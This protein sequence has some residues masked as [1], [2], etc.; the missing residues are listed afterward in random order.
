MANWENTS[1]QWGLSGLIWGVNLQPPQTPIA[2]E[3]NFRAPN[4]SESARQLAEHLPQGRAWG[5]KH[6]PDAN[7]H[8]LIRSMAASFNRVQ[9][10]IEKLSRELNLELTD[11][12][13]PEWETSVGL[14]D[15]CQG[16]GQTLQ[17]RR[18]AVISRLRRLPIV[19]KADFEV[20]GEELSGE[21]TVV[22][23]GVEVDSPI[24]EHSRFKLY[25]SFPAQQLGFT[26]DFPVLFGGFRPDIVKCVFEKI[27]PANVVV[28]FL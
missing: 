10:Q 16:L 6:N 20:L 15:D 5:N 18:D 17:E 2:P 28:I 19:T 3:S 23:P 25:V 8:K 13:L 12:L 24:D 22:T 4:L 26:Y 11:D 27:V 21:Q 1:E 7:L 14:P 9:Q